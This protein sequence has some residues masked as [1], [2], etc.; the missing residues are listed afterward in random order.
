M[1][2]KQLCSDLGIQLLS[3]QENRLVIGAMNTDY[4][5]LDNFVESLRNNFSI[6]VSLEGISSEEWERWFDNNDDQAAKSKQITAL[7]E[8]PISNNYFNG[9]SEKEILEKTDDALSSTI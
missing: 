9:N 5:K 6:Q 3:L 8:T 4:Y 1:F 7:V 2:T